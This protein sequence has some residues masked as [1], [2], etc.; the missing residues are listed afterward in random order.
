[1]NYQLNN[2]NMKSLQWSE[3]FRSMPD[4]QVTATTIYCDA[5]DEE[6]TLLVRKDWSYKCTGYVGFRQAPGATYSRLKKKTGRSKKHLQCADPEC[7]RLIAYKNRLQSE[8][9]AGER[10]VPSGEVA[11]AEAS[12]SEK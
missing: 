10:P 5:V 6:V 9:A 12:K 4:W 1:M 2:A 3:L 8:E 7:D 11:T